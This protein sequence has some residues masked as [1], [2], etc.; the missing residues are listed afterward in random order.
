MT[1]RVLRYSVELKLLEVD[2]VS[3]EQIIRWY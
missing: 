1:I 3:K 2:L